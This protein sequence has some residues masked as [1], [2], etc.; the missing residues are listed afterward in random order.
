MTI[1]ESNWVVMHWHSSSKAWLF[2]GAR[3]DHNPL[4]KKRPYISTFDS[5]GECMATP[6]GA[7]SSSLWQLKF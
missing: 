7:D 4:P 6:L 2:S 3:P 5:V 1:L